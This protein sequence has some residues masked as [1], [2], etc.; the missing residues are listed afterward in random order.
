MFEAFKKKLN[1][2]QR[3]EALESEKKA[4]HAAMLSLVLALN[5]KSEAEI[6]KDKFIGVLKEQ[7]LLMDRF[8]CSRNMEHKFKKFASEQLKLANASNSRIEAAEEDL[9]VDGEDI[10]FIGLSRPTSPRS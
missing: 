6:N 1:D 5:K 9:E 2:K 10:A 7:I 4:N 8:I 3:I